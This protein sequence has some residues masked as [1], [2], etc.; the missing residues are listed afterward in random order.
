M[1]QFWWL[2][3]T[4]DNAI[5]L[6]E[7][8]RR[9][10]GSALT[11]LS[12]LAKETLAEGL[13]R[14]LEK[15][16]DQLVKQ[17]DVTAVF[18]AEVPASESSE[19]GGESGE[20]GET[21]LLNGSQ[22]TRYIMTCLTETKKYPLYVYFCQDYLWLNIFKSGRGW[23]NLLVQQLFVPFK[24]KTCTVSHCITLWY[25]F[26]RSYSAAWGLPGVEEMWYVT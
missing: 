4:G 22:G 13:F 19:S 26:Y 14:Y 12:G 6:E 25:I 3:T 17:E 20:S 16:G 8:T 2:C 18:A 1:S 11:A 5:T 9:L 7:L 23:V 10:G 24:T 15:T 21:R